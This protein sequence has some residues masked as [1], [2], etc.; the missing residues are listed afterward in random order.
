M[1]KGPQMREWT[2]SSPTQDQATQVIFCGTHSGSAKP[3]AT[4]SISKSRTRSCFEGGETSS[5]FLGLLSGLEGGFLEEL[6]GVFRGDDFAHGDSPLVLVDSCGNVAL[7]A[8][9]LDLGLVS[10]IPAPRYA[11]NAGR[12]EVACCVLGVS[13]DVIRE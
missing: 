1:P 9:V 13:A 5:G 4:V 6:C 8:V 7:L 2:F 11:A 3:A 10:L 12:D